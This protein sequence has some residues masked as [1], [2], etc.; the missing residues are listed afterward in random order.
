MVDVAFIRNK[1][2]SDKEVVHTDGDTAL[3]NGGTGRKVS[4]EEF[5]VNNHG[6]T[7]LDGNASPDTG[8]HMSQHD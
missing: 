5:E 2:D 8:D 4:G 3:G 6:K 7:P 1:I